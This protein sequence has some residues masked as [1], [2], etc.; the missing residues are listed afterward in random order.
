MNKTNNKQCVAYA[1]VRKGAKCYLAAICIIGGLVRI[2]VAFTSLR[3]FFCWKNTVTVYMHGL[4]YGYDYGW[5]LEV[6]PSKQLQITWRPASHRKTNLA[7]ASDKYKYDCCWGFRHVSFRNRTC[8]QS[9]VGLKSSHRCRHRRWRKVSQT[10]SFQDSALR[11]SAKY[12]RP[13]FGFTKKQHLCSADNN[14]LFG[15]ALSCQIVPPRNNGQAGKRKLCSCYT[16]VY[17]CTHMFIYV[18]I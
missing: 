11:P 14:A 2:S 5:D 6:A 7:A 12:L 13:V 18:C 4:D 15:M 10:S 3:G 1:S 16:Y 17:I 9:G 8:T